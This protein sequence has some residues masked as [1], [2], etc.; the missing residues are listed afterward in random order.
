MTGAAGERER[1]L[2]VEGASI[3]QSVLYPVPQYGNFQTPE[4]I[5]LARERLSRWLAE[6]LSFL[7]DGK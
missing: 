7:K 2:L 4:E 3:A 1:A 5:R 6:V